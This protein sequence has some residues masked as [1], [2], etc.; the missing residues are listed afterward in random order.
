MVACLPLDPSSNPAEDDGFLRAINICGTISFGG[1]V[2][3]KVPCRKIKRHVNPTGMKE[4]LSRQ[5][6]AAIYS[7]ISPASLQNV[8][9]ESCGG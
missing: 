5:N 3:P 9:A 4:I 2:K 7:L 8:F 6:S 1:E